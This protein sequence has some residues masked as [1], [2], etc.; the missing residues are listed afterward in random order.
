MD[1]SCHKCGHAVAEGRPFCP[2]CGAPQIRV[3][4]PEP[5]SGPGAT[6]AVTGALAGEGVFSPVPSDVLPVHLSHGML[7]CLLAAGISIGL[8]FVGLNPLAASLGAGVL[9]VVFSARR[10]PGVPIRTGW[11]ASLGALAGLVLFGLT[12]IL[13]TLAV[14]WLHKSAEIRDAMIEKVEQ[15][16]SRYPGPDMQPFLEYVKSP[17]GFA[18]MM[19]ASVV[20]GLVAFVLLGSAGGAVTAAF[21]RRRK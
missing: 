9:A 15:A 19:V 2:E 1:H 12:V 21:L 11:G 20:F 14:V 3:L 18:V 4:I 7:S 5:V 16:A 8:M 17:D 13:E 6:E 10:N